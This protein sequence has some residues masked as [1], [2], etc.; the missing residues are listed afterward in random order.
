MSQSIWVEE[1]SRGAVLRIHTK[2]S[3]VIATIETVH[4]YEA[5]RRPDSHGVSQSCLKR[6]CDWMQAGRDRFSL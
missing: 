4:S 5:E 6:A 2:S 3:V 1:T